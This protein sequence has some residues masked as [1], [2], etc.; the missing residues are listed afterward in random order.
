MHEDNTALGYSCKV[1]F[2][3]AELQLDHHPLHVMY[4]IAKLKIFHLLNTK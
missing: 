1:S 3:P 4:I 2:T